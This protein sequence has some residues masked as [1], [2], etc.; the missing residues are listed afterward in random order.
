MDYFLLKNFL[1][2]GVPDGTD[3]TGVA[4]RIRPYVEDYIRHKYPGDFEGIATLGKCI[5][6]IK[7]LPMTTQ[8]AGAFQAKVGELADINSFGSRFM[9]SDGTPVAPPSDREV[10]TFATRAIALVQGS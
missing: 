5:E 1:D 3:L 4:R 9:H 8:G 2:H 10:R 7:S 6:K